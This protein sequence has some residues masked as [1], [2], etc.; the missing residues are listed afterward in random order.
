MLSISSDRPTW[1][2]G[3]L[4]WTSLITRAAVASMYAATSIRYFLNGFGGVIRY[5]EHALEGTWLPMPLVSGFAHVIPW[6]ELVIWIWLVVGYRLRAAWVVAGLYTVLLGF[7]NMV[8]LK[9][10]NDYLHV[11][12]C[13]VGLNT[14]HYDLLSVDAW[15]RARRAATPRPREGD[16]P[17]HGTGTA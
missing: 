7:G 2:A 11:L 1:A 9:T 10:A 12:L 14:A 5:T 16:H 15:L 8:A 6:L 13:L 4:P 3:P 17:T